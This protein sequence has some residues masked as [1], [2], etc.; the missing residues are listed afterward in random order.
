MLFC[1]TVD[2]K[3]MRLVGL[4]LGIVLAAATSGAETLSVEVRHYH[5]EDLRRIAEWEQIEKE[6]DASLER[7]LAEFDDARQHGRFR[8]ETEKGPHV[9]DIVSAAREQQVA[10]VLPLAPDLVQECIVTPGHRMAHRTWAPRFPPGHELV[11]H[12][13]VEKFRADDVLMDL[14]VEYRD[15]QNRVPSSI[16]WGHV[17]QY[18]L[19]KPFLLSANGY[20]TGY[21]ATGAKDVDL[22]VEVG[23]LRRVADSAGNRCLPARYGKGVRPL[24][25]SSAL[26]TTQPPV[27]SMPAPSLSTPNPTSPDH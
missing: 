6:K 5:V 3:A 13:L 14:I 26:P 27:D 11:M 25:R 2:K 8:E 22:D 7:R 24:D 19:E 23:V 1:G 10:L 16:L 9:P 18:P 20:N 15:G 17:Y 21:A 4:A 12:V